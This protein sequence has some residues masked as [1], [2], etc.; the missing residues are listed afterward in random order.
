MQ[1]K[2]NILQIQI[3][4]MLSMYARKNNFVFFSVPNEAA[5]L[6]VGAD[7]KKIFALIN[8]LK[9]MGMQSGVADLTIIKDGQTYFLELKSEKGRLSPNQEIFKDRVIEASA[10]YEHTNNY[11]LAIEILKSWGII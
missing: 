8:H 7:R 11:D 6:A 3:V 2:E 5:L 4:S 1:K 9:K 10:K